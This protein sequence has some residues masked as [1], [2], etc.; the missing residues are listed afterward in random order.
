MP[1]SPD[2]VDGPDDD[3]VPD[4]GFDPEDLPRLLEWEMPFGR[5]QG[6]TLIDLPEEYL[7]WFERRGFPASDLGRL[8]ELTLGIKRHGA[9]PAM[10]QLARRLIALRR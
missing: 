2:D 4:V 3:Y 10:R 8:M 9:E 7:L 1:E 6:R 5:Y